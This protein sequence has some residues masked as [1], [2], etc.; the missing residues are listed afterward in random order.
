MKI[1]PFFK[2]NTGFAVK[3][4]LCHSHLRIKGNPYGY[5]VFKLRIRCGKKKYETCVE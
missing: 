5:F 2:S 1:F 4:Y 3:Y